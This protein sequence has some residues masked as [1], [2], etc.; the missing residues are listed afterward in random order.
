VTDGVADRAGLAQASDDADWAPNWPALADAIVRQSLRLQPSE[1]VILLAD[2][3]YVPD[4]LEAVRLAIQAAGGIELAT[5]LNWSP[6]LAARR[7]ALAPSPA[8]GAA[9]WNREA[10]A[11][12]DLFQTADALIWLPRDEFRSGTINVGETEWILRSWR[13]RSVHFHWSI[14]EG[15]PRGAPVHRALERIYERGILGLDREDHARLQRE[16]VEAIRG[17]E[18][19]IT[20]PM[21]TDIRFRLEAN[22]WYHRNDGDASIAKAR[23]AT[24]A[25]DREEELPCG[26]VRVIPAPTSVSGLVSFRGGW[27]TISSGIQFDR[28]IDWLDL[29]F[30]DG[31][32]VRLTASPARQASLERE[33]HAQSGDQDRLGEVAIGTNP[34][35]PTPADATIPTY[36]GAGAGVVRLHLGTNLESGGVFES[37]VSANLFLADATLTVDDS[38]VIRDGILLLG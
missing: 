34:L 15:S 18:I 8:D 36:W 20:T 30:E 11:H 35:L 14:D 19:R 21:G 10:A 26:S 3:G 17:R 5:I 22:G 23:E 7:A 37:S 24:C 27:H 28:Y 2:P 33:W 9:R 38:P 32:I 29:D 12:R 31:R 6:A 1:R 25:R 13:G 4:L 16:L